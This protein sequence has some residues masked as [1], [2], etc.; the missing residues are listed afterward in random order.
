MQQTAHVTMPHTAGFAHP[1]RNVL[2]FNVEAGMRVADLGAGSGH[3]VW[4]IAEIVGEQGKVYAVDVQ[5]DLLKRIH[6]EAQKRGLKNVAIV[7]SDLEKPNATRLADGTVDLALVSNLLFQLEDKRAVLREAK[8]ILKKSGMLVLIDWAD[9][10]NMMGPHKGHVV[11][12]AAGMELLQTE[13]FEFMREFHAGAHH[14]GLLGR[15][16]A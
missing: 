3:Y 2:H 10:F 8:R 6:N 14:W 15:P 11:T 16:A 9:S 12:K 7:W 13:G 5:Q 1:S 4:P